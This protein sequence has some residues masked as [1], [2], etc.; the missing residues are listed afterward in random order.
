M[1]L[2]YVVWVEKL[3][4]HG[5]T[6]HK[7]TMSISSR[8]RVCYVTT[9]THTHTLR[10][11]TGWYCELR[12][13]QWVVVYAEWR[14]D[15]RRLP[16][17]ESLTRETVRYVL[18]HNI[19]HTVAYIMWCWVIQVPTVCCAVCRCVCIYTHTV[20]SESDMVDKFRE[21]TTSLSEWTVCRC[22]HLLCM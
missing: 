13:F 7:V 22:I 2:L 21:L 15:A 3:L 20:N 19:S 17:R 12:V 6:V 4:K 5:I 9:P 14:W 11:S 16:L 1:F 8:V 10:V 18:L